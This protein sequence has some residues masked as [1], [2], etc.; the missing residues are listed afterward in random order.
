MF[1]VEKTKLDGVL[2]I[3]PPT[4]HEDY[5]GQYIETYNEEL[6]HIAVTGVKFVQDDISV[7]RKNVLRGIHG[8]A[9]TW[10]LVSC[11][12]GCIWLVVVNWDPLSPQLEQW[13][14]FTLS[15]R[16]HQQVLVPPQ[17][18]NGHLVMSDI[19]MFSYKQSAYYNPKGQFTI[20]WDDARLKIWWPVS[21]P[22][23]SQRDASGGAVHE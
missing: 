6:Y 22:I 16:N 1:K 11:L 5:R 10:K 7:S 3:T 2:L 12:Y 8:D 9:E 18:G 21:S 19:A 15:D 14:A 17:F 13:A 20:R 4:I 23:I